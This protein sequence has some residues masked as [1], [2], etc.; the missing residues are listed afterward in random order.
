[1]IFIIGRR[2]LVASLGVIAI[3][4]PLSARAQDLH[5]RRLIAYLTGAARPP[6][7]YSDIFLQGM[8]ELGYV[9]G[10]DFDVTLRGSDGHEDRLPPLAEEVVGL[11]PDVILA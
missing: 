1:M 6:N 9:E 8:R 7:S 5:R 2:E 3:A 11:K 10:Q 4:W